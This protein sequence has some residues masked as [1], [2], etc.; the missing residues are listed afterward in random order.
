MQ[1]ILFNAAKGKSGMANAI[2]HKVP[3]SITNLVNVQAE[4]YKIIKVLGTGVTDYYPSIGKDGKPMSVS[5]HSLDEIIA[6]KVHRQRLTVRLLV[7]GNA[8]MAEQFIQSL[9]GYKCMAISKDCVDVYVLM[10]ESV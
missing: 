7:E 8:V 3:A 9:T 4:D 2:E 1:K 10:M 6:A 5:D